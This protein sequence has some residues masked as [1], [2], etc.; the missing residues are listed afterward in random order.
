MFSIRH[1]L[2]SRKYLTVALHFM[3][4]SLLFSTWVTYIPYVAARLQLSPARLGSAL[5]FSWVGSLSMIPLARVLIR[6]VGAGRLVVPAFAY[7][8]FAISAPF[9]APSYPLLCAGL[10]LMGTGSCCY[11]ITINSLIA[12][13]EKQDGVLTCHA[14]YS[15][16]AMLGAALGS[17]IAARFGHPL[18]HLY[19]IQALA[20]LFHLS[21]WRHYRHVAGDASTHHGGMRS[22][23][24]PLALVAL[25]GLIFMVSEGAIADWSGLYLQKVARAPQALLGFGYAAFALAMAMGR[26]LGDAVSKRFGSWQIIR[27]GSLLAVVGFALALSLPGAVSILGFFVV[28]LGFSTIVPEI[29]R[30]AAKTP[31]IDTSSGIAFIAGTANLGFMVGPVFM[32]YIAQL[33]SLRFSFLALTICVL[34]AHALGAF[35]QHLTKQRSAA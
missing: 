1:L 19:T 35:G 2:S 34:I 12:T 29:Y 26:F 4:F 18:V 33:R 10:T 28:G 24:R 22:A 9:L 17:L 30:L 8:C 21:Q 3:S 15:S 25:I 16:G 11:N 32:G 20:L 6:R 31:G 14:F 13:L 27:S 7:Y 23:I 5:F